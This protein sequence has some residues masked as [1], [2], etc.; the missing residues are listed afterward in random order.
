MTDPHKPLRPV[1]FEI[2]LL[3]SEREWHGYALMS[4]VKTRSGGRWILGPGTL[5]RTLKQMKEEGLIEPGRSA[6]P[7]VKDVD[8]SRR[9]YYRLTAAGRRVAA[10]EARRMNRLVERAKSGALISPT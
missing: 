10:A 6:E 5:Y 8:E 1:V 3:L 7:T 2:L 9:Q 4:E